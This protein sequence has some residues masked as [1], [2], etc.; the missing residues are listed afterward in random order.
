MT[1]QQTPMAMEK[2]K[3]EIEFREILKKRR[4]NRIRLLLTRTLIILGGVLLVGIV[5]GTILEF[6][7]FSQSEYKELVHHTTQILFTSCVGLL[8]LVLG[9]ER[10]LDFNNIE[11]TLD[12]QNETLAN[13]NKHFA[14]SSEALQNVSLVLNQVHALADKINAQTDLVSQMKRIRQTHFDPL[15]NVVFKDFIDD[16]IHFFQNGIENKKIIFSEH[17]RFEKAYAKCLEHLKG[18]HFLAT[19]SA[20]SNYF[21]SVEGEENNTIEDAIDE[22]IKSGGKMTRIFFVEPQDLTNARTLGVLNKQISLGVSVYL[23]SR[24]HVSVDNQKFFVMDDCKRICWHIYTDDNSNIVKFIYSA[25]DA[26]IDRYLGI[27][28]TLKSNR[29]IKKYERQLNSTQHGPGASGANG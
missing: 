21:W 2:S 6:P 14:V 1:E 24:K 10:I 3:Q 20:H 9:F 12:K 17:D 7:A 26:D 4:R 28:E 11:D 23:I 5:A 25:N 16:I 13:Q 18:C 22:F 29:H 15:L 27:F 8:C 19:S